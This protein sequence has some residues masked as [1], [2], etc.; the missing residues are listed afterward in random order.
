MKSTVDEI[1]SKLEIYAAL[2]KK[3]LQAESFSV[4]AQ[5][6]IFAPG[7]LPVTVPLYNVSPKSEKS[8]CRLV[9]WLP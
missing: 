1:A 2:R 9:Y 7:C 6:V 4:L 5:R 8:V 3:A